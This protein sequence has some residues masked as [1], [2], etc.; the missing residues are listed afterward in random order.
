MPNH[1]PHTFCINWRTFC[2]VIWHHFPRHILHISLIN[3]FPRTHTFCK[4]LLSHTYSV[5]CPDNKQ[6]FIVVFWWQSDQVTFLSTYIKELQRR[7]SRRKWG[8]SSTFDTQG[9][10]S[11][12]KRE[13]WKW[14]T[15]KEKVESKN[16][17]G[18]QSL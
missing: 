1:F 9:S 8:H 13:Q 4:Y 18:N 6:S 11:C 16:G 7:N 12:W 5:Y 2:T 14:T 10:C 17:N 15:T 3:F